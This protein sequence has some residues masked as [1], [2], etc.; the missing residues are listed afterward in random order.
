MYITGFVSPYVNAI[1]RELA[2]L[3]SLL[4]F[5]PVMSKAIRAPPSIESMARHYSQLPSAAMWKF[6][7]KFE[8]HVDDRDTDSLMGEVYYNNDGF[9][10]ANA[11]KLRSYVFTL[12]RSTPVGRQ[13]TAAYMRTTVDQAFSNNNWHVCAFK[14]QNHYNFG[15]EIPDLPVNE[16]STAFTELVIGRFF[17]ALFPEILEDFMGSKR[18]VTWKA[19]EIKDHNN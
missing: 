12:E 17:M 2:L 5:L 9:E 8:L 6:V 10:I 13:R 16:R 4:L 7:P 14:G 11:I 18:G 1:K 15:I 19:V 3:L